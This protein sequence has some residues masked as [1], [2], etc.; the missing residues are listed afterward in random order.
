MRYGII[1]IGILVI[2]AVIRLAYIQ[3]AGGSMILEPDSQGYYSAGNFFTDDLLH[4]FFNTNRTP[5]YTMLTS[6]A[7]SATTKSHPPYQSPQFYSGI[8]IILLVQ[9]IFGLIGLIILYDTLAAIGV[10]PVWNLAFTA[11]TAVNLYQFIWERAFLTE[12]PYIF[13]FIILMRLFVSLMK[14]PTVK[15]GLL[16]TFLAVWAFEIRP[17][18][19]LVPFILLPIVWLMHR[20]KK[21]FFLMAALLL[22]YCAVPLAHLKMNKKLYDFKGLSINTDFAIFG[23][24]L[25]YICRWM[26]QNTWN[27]STA[28]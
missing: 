21:V 20:T 4:N 5:G 10:P 11:L 22:F 14:K 23:R 18:G 15:I 24:M 9:T 17:T 7:L 25:H 2:A 8:W 3:Y 19:L 12:A 1:L 28:K 6:L 26:R 16:F 27:R 13:L